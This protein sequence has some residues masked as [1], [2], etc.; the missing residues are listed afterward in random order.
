[1]TTPARNGPGGQRPAIE[2][3]EVRAVSVGNLRGFATVRIG[4]VMIKGWRIV[5]EDGKKAWVSPPQERGNDGRYYATVKIDNPA[6]LDAIRSAVLEA[7]S[8]PAQ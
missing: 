3:S 2:V 1:M 4:C 5:K 6:V 7:W 8:E